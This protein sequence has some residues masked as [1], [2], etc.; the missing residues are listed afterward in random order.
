MVAQG[1][2]RPDQQVEEVE[3]PSLRLAPLVEPADA[4]Q[5]PHQPSMEVGAPARPLQRARASLVQAA[6]LAT[7]GERLG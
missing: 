7:L 4:G 3:D 6:I 2:T 1:V 5:G